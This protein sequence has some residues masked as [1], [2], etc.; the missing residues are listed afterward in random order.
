MCS[1]VLTRGSVG[2]R[3]G[4]ASNGGGRGRG[5][6]WAAPLKRGS[7]RMTRACGSGR[8]RRAGPEEAGK[9]AASPT[10]AAAGKGLPG[11]GAYIVRVTYSQV[12]RTQL[13]WLW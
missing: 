5:P 6:G 13:D 10:S 11:V 3:G 12:H 2:F 1:Q 4:P 7:G 9:E 8:A